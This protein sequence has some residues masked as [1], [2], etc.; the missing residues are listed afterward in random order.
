MP[1]TAHSAASL[2]ASAWY[3]AVA[4][5][6]GNPIVVTDA[7]RRIVWVNAAFTRRTGYALDE[8]RG[9]HPGRLFQFDRTDPATVRRIGAALSEGRAVREPIENRN[10]RGERYWIDLDIQPVHDSAGRLAGFV[11]VQTDITELIAARGRL[12]DVIAGARIGT[13]EWDVPSGVNRVNDIWSGMIG[14]ATAELEPVTIDV[15]RRLI[16]PLDFPRVQAALEKVLSGSA[17]QF[18][19]EFRFHHKDGHWVHVLSSGRVLERDADG[20]PLRMA[21]VHVDVTARRE[22]EQ[23]LAAESELQQALT[24]T[25]VSGIVAFDDEGRIVFANPEAGRVLGMAQN[26]LLGR[27]CNDPAWQI[28]T[29]DGRCLPECEMPFRQVMSTAAPVQDKRHAI[30]LPDGRRRVLSV[31][32]APLPRRPMGASV[33]CAVTD[34]TEQIAGECALKAAIADAQAATERYRHM[35]RLSRS[36]IWEVDADLRFKHLSKSYAQITGLDPA[37][38]LGR[39]F[40][41]IRVKADLEYNRADFDALDAIVEARAPFS[42]FVYGVR[43]SEGHVQWMQIDG[44]P[45]FDAAGRFAGYR[46]AGSDVTQLYEM[47]M[48]AEEASKAKSDFLA[49]M[50]HEIRT[51]LNGILGMA[52]LIFEAAEAPELREKVG[53]IRDSGEALLRVLNDVLDLSRIDVGRLEFDTAPFDPAEIAR[54]TCALLHPRALEK[55]LDCRLDLSPDPGPPRLGDANRVGQIVNNLV[56]NAVKFTDTGQVTL[57]IANPPD[58]PLR[59]I[60]HDTGIGMTAEQCA[61]VFQPFVQADSSIARRFGGTGLGL[62]IV[63]RLVDLMQGRVEIDSAEGAGTRITVELPLPVA[64]SPAAGPPVVCDET[65]PPQPSLAGMRVLVAE[66]NRTNL[67]ILRKMLESLGVEAVFAEDGRAACACWTAGRFDA[68]LFD[69]NMPEMDGRT[70][71]ATLQARAHAEGVALP[72]AAAITAAAMAH[73]VE[74]HTACGFARTLTKPF[75]KDALVEVLGALRCHG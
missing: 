8:V 48:R 44:E 23:A 52:E 64:E 31:N 27:P 43:R 5:R 42:D 2:D 55:G 69:I 61:R 10:R 28:T 57:R 51:P 19:Y 29:L 3:R 15:W 71:L 58:G 38:I 1:D 70:A 54:R 17:E 26:D 45:I 13:W 66:D 53:V 14:Y 22:L 7:A 12:D 50:S 67:I 4:E 35:A 34:I 74:A 20:R 30:R 33:V 65:A 49:M 24:E 21:G 39:T 41:E 32:A 46:G 63:R 36:W 72:P 37:R 56:G 16:H 68:L 47:R 6:T 40:S 75:R 73:E 9:A 25:S 60:V 18:E 11:G 59:L 62:S